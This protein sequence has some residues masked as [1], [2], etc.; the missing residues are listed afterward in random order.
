M[1]VLTKAGKCKV[2]SCSRGRCTFL[3][4]QSSLFPLLHILHE[5]FVIYTRAKKTIFLYK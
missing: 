3:R 2:E 1:I 4:E 5:L